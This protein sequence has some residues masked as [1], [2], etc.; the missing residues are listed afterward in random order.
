[1]S[2]VFTFTPTGAGMS[3]R[4]Y[5]ECI[6]KLTAAGAANPK[7]R[8]YHVCYGDADNLSVTDVWDTVENFQ[9]FGA[10]LMPILEEMGIDVGQPRVQAVYNIIEAPAYAG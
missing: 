1:M 10:V 9:K 2:F 3:S 7:G 8:I 6:S 5:D 4:K